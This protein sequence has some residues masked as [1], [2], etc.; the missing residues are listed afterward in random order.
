MNMTAQ[1]L[2]RWAARCHADAK[3]TRCIEDRERLEKMSQSLLS[4][5]ENQDWLIPGD[6]KSNGA[7]FADGGDLQH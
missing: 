1:E 3:K 5:A 4:L 2:R 7:T 6:P